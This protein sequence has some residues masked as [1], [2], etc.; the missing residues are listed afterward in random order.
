[1]ILSG[2][3]ME[4][5]EDDHLRVNISKGV[6]VLFE[7]RKQHLIDMRPLAVTQRGQQ[8]ASNMNKWTYLIDPTINIGVSI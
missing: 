2:I 6:P 8:L 7:I 5:Q 1:M 4:G 3:I